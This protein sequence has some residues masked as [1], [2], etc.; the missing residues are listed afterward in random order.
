[1]DYSLYLVTDGFNFNEEEF[2]Q[3]VEQA[4]Q[5]GVT[6]VQYR[7]KD[8]STNEAY[9]LALKIQ[10][11]TNRYDVP[12]IINDRLDICLAIDADGIHIGDDELPVHVV[13]KLLGPDKIIGVSAKTVERSNE[14]ENEGADYL[15]VGAIFPTNTKD[16]DVIPL[17]L[18]EEITHEVSIPVVAIGG[19]KLNNVEFLSGIN[20]EG[21][22]LVS[23]IMLAEDINQTVQ[24]LL[25]KIEKIKEEQ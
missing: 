6:L 21:I 1:M 11:I 22:S 5:A 25:D 3:R 13:R 7:D 20:I 4:I 18:L 23:E 2:L 10:K 12:L 15:G 19:L 9:Q 8:V 16:S 24:A 14:A 17:S